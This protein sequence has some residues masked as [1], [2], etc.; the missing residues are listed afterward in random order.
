MAGKRHRIN[1]NYKDANSSES[2]LYTN[3]T[4]FADIPSRTSMW[5][6]EICKSLM[7]QFINADKVNEIIVPALN[8]E[9]EYDTLIL[10]GW[11]R[12]NFLYSNR[13][14]II[15][16]ND[17]NIR[18]QTVSTIIH[19]IRAILINENST[20]IREVKIDAFVLS[21][22]VYLGFDKYPL[23][24]YPQCDYTAAV[25]H[26]CSITSKIE[27]IV[28][29]EDQ[30]IVLI[31]EDKHPGGISEVTDW[32]E[33][34]IAG[35]IFV[36]AFHNIYMGNQS[37]NYTVT[38][39][40]IIYAVRIDGTKFTFYKAEVSRKY[41][42]ECSTSLPYTDNL[43]VKRFPPQ[44]DESPDIARKLNAW[45]FCNQ[46]ERINILKTLKALHD[47]NLL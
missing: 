19:K 8:L 31:A 18:P 27:F 12:D 2:N 5:D 11:N 20:S 30:Y 47:S 15:E 42:K 26:N 16:D 33:P 34:Q 40:L 28:S 35:E 23:I 45:D 29:K 10:D 4:S 7:I 24:I 9:K 32:C 43:I 36:T 17:G 22:L 41:L 25:A 14:S 13:K 39:P 38:Y 1:V 6:K 3:I 37:D 44:E 46:S 21:L